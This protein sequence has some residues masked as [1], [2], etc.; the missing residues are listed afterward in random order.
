MD[1]AAL[2]RM[3]ALAG[4]IPTANWYEINY[5]L[6]MSIDLFFEYLIYPILAL[7]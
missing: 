4:A 2:H 6:F 5:E 1:L 7:F 3:D